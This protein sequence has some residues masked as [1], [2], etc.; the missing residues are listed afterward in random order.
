M[1]ST[2]ELCD[3]AAKGLPNKHKQAEANFS[4]ANGS[5][6]SILRVQNGTETNPQ[7]NRLGLEPREET[8]G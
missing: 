3:R 5:N 4:R 6:S 1:N 2:V 8:T 7:N